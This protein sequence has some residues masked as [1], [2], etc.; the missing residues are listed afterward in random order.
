MQMNFLQ[1]DPKVEYATA[2]RLD[3]DQVRDETRFPS[4]S[5]ILLMLFGVTFLLQAIA[6]LLRHYVNPDGI[7][8][9]HIT[10]LL[11]EGNLQEGFKDFGVNTF[12]YSL[13][14]FKR[15]GLDPFYAGIWLNVVA[16]SLTVMPLFGWIRRMFD[17]RIAVIGS[18]LFA[19]HPIIL[20][21]GS[22]LMR[23]PIFGLFFNLSIYAA[24]RA[25]TEVRLRWFLVAGCSL[26]LAVHTRSEA[27]FLV[28]PIL[29]WTLGRLWFTNGYRLRL[30]FGTLL[31]LAIVPGS[32]AVMNLT[33]LKTH[34][35]WGIFRPSHAQQLGKF[36]Q[37][38]KEQ[39]K[40]YRTKKK[41][42]KPAPSPSPAKKLT[43][44]ADPPSFVMPGLRRALLRVAKSYSYLYGIY[45]LI[46]ACVW[47]G[48]HRF[49]L[50]AILLMAIP[51]F[52]VVWHRS[53]ESDV[54]PRY[55]LPIV[56]ISLPFIALGLLWIVQKLA[57]FFEFR[58]YF[59]TKSSAYLVGVMIFTLIVCCSSAIWGTNISEQKECEL[60]KW[61]LN[62]F[63]PDQKI[64][65][66]NRRS[67]M[68]A[69]YAKSDFHSYREYP[70]CGPNKI[71][72]NKTT[73]DGIF[74]E[75]KPRVVLCWENHRAL[76][77]MKGLF[78]TLREENYYG[79]E[80]AEPDVLAKFEPKVLVLV[81]KESP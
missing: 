50:H 5:K 58:K 69:W 40:E 74:R 31:L 33:V 63:G 23:D 59:P 76:R 27:W 22:A 13:V 36:Y 17:M 28:I 18:L 24:W 51:L 52:I 25:I 57:S 21:I 70:V 79:Y 38:T 3:V 68:T 80:V 72:N 71:P 10:D 77:E 41:E 66:I 16:S 61:V 47:R 35:Q 62:R 7:T 34:P 30:G 75:V 19:F 60:G 49:A 8:Y 48:S 11:A 53:C 46:G 37:K 56:F 20:S 78:E 64:Y 42:T 45:G 32:I 26:T 67:R 81:R 39:V 29:L 55:F 43:K 6:A 12:I 14:L 44:P 65:C 9:L 4:S 15:L 1:M 54:S 2:W 73:L